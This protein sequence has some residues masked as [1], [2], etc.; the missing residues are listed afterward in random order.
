MRKQ[1]D[2]MPLVEVVDALLAPDGCPWD[3]AQS[4]ESMRKHLIEEAYEVCDAIDCKDMDNLREE[5]GDVLFQVVFHAALAEEEEQF[6]LQGVIDE[7][8]AKMKRRHP[9]IY[10]PA[11]G[12][13]A[14]M[15]WESIKRAEKTMKKQKLTLPEGLPVLMKL[16]KLIGKLEK[17]GLS[18][19]DIINFCENESERKLLKS[20]Y[21]YREES[22]PI[23]LS[24]KNLADRMEAQLMDIQK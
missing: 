4:H 20:V 9:R 22:R 16:D 19:E 12:A 17:K 2:V 5:L 15:D 14:L 21:C 24:A 1:I 8:V 11:D 10:P 23:E 13:E 7:V 18:T 6:D 3:R